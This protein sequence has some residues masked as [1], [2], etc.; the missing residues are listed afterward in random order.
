MSE[1]DKPDGNARFS[2]ARWSERKRAAARGERVDDAP[3]ATAPPVVPAATVAAPAPSSVTPGGVGAPAPAVGVP[4][5]P[6][7]PI[8]SLTFES[9]F[10]AF[11]QGGV[12]A[13]VKRAA[14]RKLLRDPRFNVMDGLDVYID[15]YSR[16]DPIPPEMLARLAHSVATLNPQ[17]PGLDAHDVAA[18][19]GGADA[20]GDGHAGHATAADADAA[21]RETADAKAVSAA[22]PQPAVLAHTVDAG[23]GPCVPTRETPPTVATSTERHATPA[24]EQDARTARDEDRR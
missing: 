13:D 10:T 6:L 5:A 14:L 4:S 9:D 20:P 19:D 11:M 8:Q 7:P 3:A 1:Q 23:A 15:D 2:L 12:D 24:G 18:S 21:N 16:P 17:G 22:I